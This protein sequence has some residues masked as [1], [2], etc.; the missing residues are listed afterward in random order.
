MP[1]LNHAR[2]R[3]F[4]LIELVISAALMSII[5]MAAYACLRAGLLSRKLVETRS[6]VVQNARVA[7]SLISADLRCAGPLSIK[8]EFLGLDRMIEETEAD[9]I[10]F[11]THNFS[12]RHPREGDFCEVSYYL[13]KNT[14]GTFS[15]WRRRDPTPDAEPLEGGALEEIAQG[16]K[17][18]SFEYY[19]GFEWFDD[20]GDPEG[21]RQGQDTNLLPSNMLGMPDAVRIT[22]EFVSEPRAATGKPQDTKTEVDG[23]VFQ[24]V[25]RLNLASISSSR[26]SGSASGASPS[27][28]STVPAP[29]VTGN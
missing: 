12:P 3:A 10:D 25:V 21:R 20:W 23:L 18:L 28:G 29:A 19:D 7:M 6:D 9:N 16:L 4:T 22:L 26:S 24:S 13:D 14:N 15:L 8:Y 27:P 1:P 2:R 5:L 17:S 11:A